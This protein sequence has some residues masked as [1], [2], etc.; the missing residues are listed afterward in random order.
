MTFQYSY[1]FH[2]IIFYY[3]VVTHTTIAKYFDLSWINL[4]LFGL[5][6]SIFYWF[7]IIYKQVITLKDR[8]LNTSIK[9]NEK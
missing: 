6:A 9:N 5:S 4:S 7:F 8:I 1:I 3:I 2:M